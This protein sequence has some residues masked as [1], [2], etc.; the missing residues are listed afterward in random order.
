MSRAI[1]S[2]LGGGVRPLV[3]IVGFLGM[4]AVLW[5]PI[6]WGLAQ[7][8]TGPVRLGPLLIQD[9]PVFA[10][11]VPLYL[12]FIGLL[13][14]WG[15]WLHHQPLPLRFYG[16]RCD[17]SQLGWLIAGLVLGFGSA[18]GALGV[19]GAWGWL[20]WQAPSR[21]LLGLMLEA[22]VVALLLSAVEELL[23]RG[24]LLTELQLGYGGRGA[25]VIG[26]LIFALVHN[27]R[28]LPET[29]QFFAQV[30]LGL[31]LG[32]ARWASGGL[33]YGIGLH[34][35]LVWLNYGVTVG[36]MTRVGDRV[37]VLV[38]GIGGNPLAGAAGIV[39]MAG[40]MLWVGGQA[41]KS[42]GP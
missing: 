12:L 27:L 13:R 39:L 16:W 18:L 34:A 30:L 4:L 23:F 35:G 26:A 19:Q 1:G 15:R 21:P 20:S 40:L 29:G 14:F 31:A 17:R 36:G 38:T 33:A 6:A 8:V 10:T 41:R 37:S 42:F 25:L 3:R 32:L 28:P 24:W 9:A 22:G 5:A 2:R 7:V 11:L